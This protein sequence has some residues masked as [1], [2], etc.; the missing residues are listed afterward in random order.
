[1]GPG[2]FS[3]VRVTS[4][5]V[6]L[7]RSMPGEIR[8]EF[9]A[10]RIQWQ[11]WMGMMLFVLAI[12][13]ALFWESTGSIPSAGKAVVTLIGLFFIGSETLRHIV[14]APLRYRITASRDLLTLVLITLIGER[15]R[16]IHSKDIQDIVLQGEELLIV[17]KQLRISVTLQTPFRKS[18]QDLTRDE[19]AAFRSGHAA[20]PSSEDARYLHGLIVYGMRS[21]Q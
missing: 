1:M 11:L 10:P 13:G 21:G 5:A 8:V 16:R 18:Y 3:S 6:V 15:R 14:L 4:A 17:T 7:L 2:T 12:I 20:F 19:Q 9:P